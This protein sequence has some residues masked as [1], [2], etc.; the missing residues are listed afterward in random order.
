MRFIRYFIWLLPAYGILAFAADFSGFVLDRGTNHPIP[1]AIITLNDTT[2]RT[3]EDGSF[4]ISGEA[5]IVQ[6]RASG[7]HRTSMTL[8]RTSEPVNIVLSRFEAKALYLTVYGVGAPQLRDN[9]LHLID[10]TELNALVVDL[11]GD[12]GIVPW[13]ARTP[14]ATKIGARNK[15][16]SIPDL[17]DFAARMHSRGIYL[18]ARIVVFKDN[19]L[20]LCH[21]ELAVKTASGA[22]WRDREGL[23]WVDPFRQEVR[24]YNI[25][26]AE[27]AAQAGFDEIQFDYVRF[28]DAK[29]LRFFEESTTASREHAIKL[30]FEQVR[31]RLARYNVF[32]SGDIFGYVC[33]NEDDTGIGQL[34]EQIAPVLDYTS[35]M[36]YPSGFEFGIPGYKNPVAHPFEIVKLSLDRARDRT[37]LPPSRFRPWLQAFRDYAFDHRNFDAEEIKDQILAADQFG[38]DGW[39]LWNARN[40][41]SS[42]GLSLKK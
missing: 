30:L 12:A 13:R 4:R 35:P 22:I 3:G 6:A 23:S 16:T 10:A 20:A 26:L 1:D 15:I 33:W 34:I 41:Y 28:P 29:G 21:R 39:M 32:I 14:L 18:I 37:H 42:A 24:D 25:S 7:Y 8:S 9:A 31:K 11:K 19:P 17:T 38:S 36:L 5:S 40:Q 2:V 27:E